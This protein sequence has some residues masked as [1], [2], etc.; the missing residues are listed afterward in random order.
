MQR[1][2]FAAFDESEIDQEISEDLTW[3]VKTD[4]YHIT[5]DGEVL[6]FDYYDTEKKEPVPADLTTPQKQQRYA[7]ESV[8]IDG[9]DEFDLEDVQNY[10]TPTHTD[11]GLTGFLTSGTFG[12][13][14]GLY[15]GTG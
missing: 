8:Q 15:F 9:F 12:T 4:Q 11:S 14:T 3:E 5:C 10:M 6:V 2:G 1:N 13:T 7:N